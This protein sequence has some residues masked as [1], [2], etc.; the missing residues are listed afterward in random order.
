MNKFRK[1]LAIATAV[2]SCATFAGCAAGGGAVDGYSESTLEIDYWSS[3]YGIPYMKALVEE[4][5]KDN[6]DIDVQLTLSSA[7]T[8]GDIY[9]RSDDNT[10]DLYISTMET[11]MAY[12][13]LLEPLDDVLT[14]T[15]DGVQVKDRLGEEYLSAMKQVDGH[16]YAL[17]WADGLCGLVYNADV[18]DEKGYTEPKTTDQ[19][20]SLALAMKSDGY[21]PFIYYKDYWMYMIQVWMQQLVGENVFR[22]YWNGEWTNSDGSKEANSI[23]VFKETETKRDVFNVLYDLFS[24]KGYTYTGTNALSH[25]VAQTYFLNGYGLMMPNGSWIQA[26]MK[27]TESKVKNIKMMKA[28]VISSLG[29]QIGLSENQL[30]A[31]VAYVDGDELT[32]AQQTAV[33][34]MS[35]ETIERVREARNL[36]YSEKTQFHML[37]PAYAAGKD[38]AKRFISFYYSDKALRIQ[39]EN[40]VK[41]SA[42]YSDGTKHKLSYENSSVFDQSLL[43]IDNDCKRVYMTLNSKLMYDGG[44]NRLWH[45]DP[46]ASFTYGTD[47]ITVDKYFEKENSY[48]DGEWANI[49]I[50]ADLA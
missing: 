8:T 37:I 43:R 49:L 16:T 31:A 32:L 30:I 2:T 23:K 5:K 25:T 33:A 21:T 47:M 12:S 36:T 15:S 7:V 4:F 34:A 26:E 39:E 42:D 35:E 40:G 20:I 44:I 24:P 22:G 1:M 41:L 6:P 29:K 10:T 48:W 38:A 50:N 28:P 3:G 9:N 27:S 17:P 18:F 19:L 45:Y 11:Y 14:M 46:V 13:N